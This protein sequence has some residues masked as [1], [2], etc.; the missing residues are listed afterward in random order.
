MSEAQ[1]DI[2]QKANGSVY[3]PK[4]RLDFFKEHCE[5]ITG[6]DPEDINKFSEFIE[7]AIQ[8]AL[9]NS[10]HLEKKNEELKR[11]SQNL[12]DNAEEDKAK[13]K[14][15]YQRIEK[16][17]EEKEDDLVKEERINLIKQENEE[18]KIKIEDQAVLITEKVELIENLHKNIAVITEQNQ[19]LNDENNSKISLKDNQVIVTL[20]SFQKQLFDKFIKNQKV[21]E[22][23]ERQNQN[24]KLDGISDIINT[25]D[26]KK[27]IANFMTTVCIGSAGNK[28]LEKLFTPQQ[29]NSAILKYI[30]Q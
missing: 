5:Q 8:T 13:I 9:D 30:E 7:L 10:D 11:I 2:F 24:G 15:L 14:E 20:N 6:K 3:F 17:E 28:V 29:L 4:K 23:F 19:N 27:D 22:I 12:R 16:L 21:I 1:K 18:L 25:G 26:Y